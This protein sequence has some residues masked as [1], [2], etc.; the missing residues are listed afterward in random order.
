MIQASK[1]FIG[2]YD[3][4]SGYMIGGKQKRQKEKTLFGIVKHKTGIDEE[5]LSIFG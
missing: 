2:Q 4:E 1:D 5:Y 3:K